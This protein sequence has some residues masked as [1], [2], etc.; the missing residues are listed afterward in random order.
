MSIRQSVLGEVAIRSGLD[1]SGADIE[2]LLRRLLLYESVT[3]KSVRLRELPCL[4][5]AFGKEGFLQLLNSGVLKIACEIS[6]IISP[7]SKNGVRALQPL[8]FS[9]GMFEITDREAT[10]RSELRRLQGVPGLKNPDREIIEHAVLSKLV[11][12]PSDY[13]NQ[14]LAQFESDL[15]TQTPALQVATSERLKAK[16]G[17]IE[18]PFELKV[19]EVEHRTFR[20]SNDLPKVFGIS[21][22]DA[23]DILGQAVSAV[24]HIDHRI[25]DMAAYSAITG[26]AESEAPLLFGK[27]A[28]IMKSQNPKTSDAQ[29]ARVA[30]I[31]EFPELAPGK[32]VDVT[33]LLAAR[34]SLE[35]LE[36][37]EWISKLEGLT[38]EQIR[39]MIGG[40]KNRLSFM[41]RSGA[42]RTLRL[43]ATTAI[44]LAGP[45]AGVLAGALDTFLLERF[46]PSSGV[47]AFLTKTYPS[48]FVSD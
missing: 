13:L 43:A 9:F 41:I 14:L 3:I 42:G 5:R 7:L 19:E 11:R 8:H 46:F 18:Q 37:R 28:G 40:V 32:R 12:P 17:E 26:F 1:V 44:G 23:H 10:L 38:D 24:G 34:D 39:D 20:I 27:L 30:T 33:R 45:I 15:R 29:F 16:L 31:A 22:Q 6:G 4:V 47:L 2:G 48:L 25:A 36:F 21:E 35:L